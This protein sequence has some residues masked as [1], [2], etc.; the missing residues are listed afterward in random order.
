[1]RDYN[2]KDDAIKEL[3][4][5]KEDIQANWYEIGRV[6]ATLINLC[7]HTR[8][9]SSI[10]KEMDLSYRTARYLM[11]LYQK[12][13]SMGIPP[14][15]GISWRHLTEVMGVLT[16]YNCDRIFQIC[17]EKKR[18]ELIE[19]MREGELGWSQKENGNVQSATGSIIP[20]YKHAT[21]AQWTWRRYGNAVIVLRYIIISQT[22]MPAAKR[23]NNYIKRRGK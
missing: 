6:C 4:E 5:L 11:S 22:P 9:F 20:N 14:P 18:E 10:L 23:E 17:R 21:V 7:K 8:D 16:Y 1:M 15:E 3:G 13:D 12:L 19:I 2:A